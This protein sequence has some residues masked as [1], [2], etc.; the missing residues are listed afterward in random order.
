MAHAGDGSNGASEPPSDHDGERGAPPEERLEAPQAA[1]TPDA[2]HE[3]E[4]H[5]PA[6]QAAG[7]GFGGEREP[8]RQAEP[9]PNA[10]A[11]LAGEPAPIHAQPVPEPEHDDPSRP[12]RK[13]WWQRR[14]SGT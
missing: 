5:E 4:A 11:P 1:A 14:F 8:S 13:G 7:S 6:W 2:R 9:S 12:A 10:E 3:P